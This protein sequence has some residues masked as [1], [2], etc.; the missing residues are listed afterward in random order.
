MGMN[1]NIV[2]KPKKEE[3]DEILDEDELEVTV[4]EKKSD[5]DPKKKMIRFM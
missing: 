1:F 4:E 3:D 2:R 5:Y